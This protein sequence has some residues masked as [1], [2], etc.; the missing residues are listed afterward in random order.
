MAS[1][2]MI[3]FRVCSDRIIMLTPIDD[4]VANLIVAQRVLAEQAEERH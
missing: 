3:F 2:S 1:A 4:T